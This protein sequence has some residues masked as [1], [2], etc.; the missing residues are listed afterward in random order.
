MELK[1]Q[2]TKGVETNSNKFFKWIRIRKIARVP[3][4]LLRHTALR[5]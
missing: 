1:E 5:F 2:I 3:V 4:I